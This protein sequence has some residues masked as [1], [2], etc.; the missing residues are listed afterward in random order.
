MV[1]AVPVSYR[2]LELMLLDRGVEVDHTTMFRCIQAYVV[3]RERRIRPHLRKGLWR[4]DETDM[5]VRGRWMYLYCGVDSCGQ[6]IDFL[7]SVKRDAEATKRFFHKALAQPHTVNPLTVT[8][9]R[10]PPIQR[11]PP[12]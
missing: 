9:D 4:V 1:S 6:T 7:L 2:D 5:K 8:V 10:M 11:P 12:R 3:E